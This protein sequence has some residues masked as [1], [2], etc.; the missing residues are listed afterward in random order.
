MP[1]LPNATATYT[2]STVNTDANSNPND[3]RQVEVLSTNMLQGI[4]SSSFNTLKS[5]QYTYLVE[6]TNAGATGVK[7]SQAQYYV[8]LFVQ[9]NT[10]T[11]EYFIDSVQIKQIKAD[12]GSTD[13]LDLVPDTKTT[14][15]NTTLAD[16]NFVFKNV[17]DKKDGNGGPFTSGE[18]SLSD[19]KGFA[20]YKISTD[21]PAALDF[22][23]DLTL[24]A[25]AGAHS[26]SQSPLPSATIVSATG[27]GTTVQNIAAYGETTTFKLKKGEKLVLNNVLMGST[28]KVEETEAQGFTPTVLANGAG[29]E[30]TSI[31]TMK[32]TGVILSDD[33]GNH[34]TFTNTTQDP[35]GVLLN[36]LPFI[37]LFLAAAG[38]IT[39][40]VRNR[41]KAYSED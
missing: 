17:Y 31:D 39:L 8:T 33:G 2:S 16:N 23:F 5:G 28:A 13:P 35:V 25:P 27:D 36:N 14:Y 3:G 24:T 4:T 22:V 37:I 11:D 10:S 41:R 9:K 12:G 26:A 21:A 1:A 18:L 40:F 6:E 15:D 19:K 20:V 7:Y 38:G 29:G 34:A 32:T 30:V